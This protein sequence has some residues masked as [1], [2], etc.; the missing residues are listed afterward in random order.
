MIGFRQGGPGMRILA[1]LG[2]ISSVACAAFAQ[3]DPVEERRFPVTFLTHRPEDT[4]STPLGL[5]PD[6]IG[7]AI[8]AG[9]DQR[10]GF[11]DPD[12]L[13]AIL[14]GDVAPASWTL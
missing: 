6:A 2:I 10:R 3:A 5:A 12:N 4:T 8:A 13:V 1:L 11:V 14:K 9:S 7:T